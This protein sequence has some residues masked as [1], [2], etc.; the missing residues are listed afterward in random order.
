[1]LTSYLRLSGNGKGRECATLFTLSLFGTF[2]SFTSHSSE[3]LAVTYLSTCLTSKSCIFVGIEQ[4]FSS[5]ATLK[6]RKGLLK[7]LQ[8]HALSEE[9]L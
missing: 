2:V 7:L 1:M 8:R 4:D 6:E 5:L 9:R 3:N